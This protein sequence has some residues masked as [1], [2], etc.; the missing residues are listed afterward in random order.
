MRRICDNRPVGVFLNFERVKAMKVAVMGFGVV[1]S[2]VAELLKKNA[3]VIKEN[4]GADLE[5][6]RILDIRDFPNSEFAPLL[7]KDFCDIENDDEIEVVV[8]TMGGLNPAFDFVSRC[9]KKKKHVV[10]SNKELV[11]QKGFELLKLAEENNVNFLFEASVGGGIP[12]IRPISRC[13]AGNRIDSI[14]G[15]LNGTTNFIMTKM[16]MER[17]GFSD[18]LSLTQKLGYA[19]KDPTADVEG[20]DACRKICILSSLAFG[21]HVYPNE[22]HTEGISK[23]TL[24]DVEDA[25]RF[26][27][28]IKLI[29]QAKKLENGKIYALVSPALVKKE[30]MLAG[31]SDVFNAC[32]VRGDMTGDILLYGKGAGASATASAVVGDIIDCADNREKRKVFGWR[33]SVPGLI[34]DYRKVPVS[35]FVRIEGSKAEKEKVLSLL[36]PEKIF[37]KTEKNELSF[38]TRIEPEEE[39]QKKLSLGGFKVLSSIRVTDY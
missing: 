1:G 17:T 26:G 18:A 9:L 28:V 20:L 29:A 31:V 27:Y 36:N 5:V 3:P 11:A 35:L 30:S 2:G 15:I 6:K 23:I 24:D 10:S 7:T 34:E 33:E 37:E 22:V 14:A 4:T 32:L 38:I 25:D 19:E 16:I 39:L 8:E 21:H 13:L 12:I